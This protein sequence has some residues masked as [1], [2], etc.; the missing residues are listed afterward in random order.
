MCYVLAHMLAKHN[1]VAP[2]VRVFDCRYC[3]YR[4]LDRN[5][6]LEHEAKH[7][8]KMHIVLHSV[9][10]KLLLDHEVSINEKCVGGEIDGTSFPITQSVSNTF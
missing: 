1:K 2:G 9:L 3:D 10:S 6:H 5:R 7:T 8:G 4:C